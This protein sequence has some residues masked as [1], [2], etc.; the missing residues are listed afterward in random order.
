MSVSS[1][2]LHA[3][4]FPPVAEL[5]LQPEFPDP[6]LLWSGKRV[7]T[8]VQ[9]RELRRPELKT[10][11]QHY[12]YGFFPPAPQNVSAHLDREDRQYFAGKATK[13]ELTLRFGP[14][15]TP[16]IHLLLM[17]P[18]ERRGPAPVFVGLHFCGNHVLLDDPA[19]PLPAVWMPKSCP[20]CEDN[21]A[22]DAG[23]GAHKD[24]WALDQ[25]ISRG[26]A[27]ATCYCGD[28]DPDRNDFT[29]G[30]HPHFPTRDGKA[31][32]PHDWGT[33]AAWAWG[34]MRCVDY[35]VT[36]K[37]LD[38]RR[39]AVVGHSRLGKTALLA[40]AF[41]D[42]IALVIPHQA[43]CGG[44]APSRKIGLALQKAESVKRINTSFPHWFCDEFKQFNDQVDRLPFDQHC[45][46]A[47]CAPRP[48]LMTNALEDQ[49]AD[50]DGQFQVLQ[51]ADPVYRL[52]GTGGL[53]AQSRPEP[54]KLVSSTLG[55]YIREGKHSMTR[56]DWLIY[57]EFAD[58]HMRGNGP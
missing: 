15:G 2:F 28:I 21:R 24:V 30:V 34:L 1:D 52:L 5:K 37:D 14:A 33:I 36:D 48:V 41:D 22:S 45:L 18:N 50:P 40:G 44:S 53:E 13:K 4:S 57:F 29:D 8:P 43:G 25:S 7:E 38:P 39:I 12:M 32:G 9:W 35:L 31:R 10:L 51:G 47:L 11:F 19:I 58:R 54:G 55:Y 27:V 23:R 46:V 6:L 56:E 17:I 42:R 16:P 26:Y 20:G 3:Q 49:W